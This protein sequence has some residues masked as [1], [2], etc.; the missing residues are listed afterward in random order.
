MRYFLVTYTTK[1]G[2]QIDEVVSVSKNARP[3]D[4]Q[5]CS[6]IMDYKNKKVDKCVIEGKKVDTD[7]EKLDAY[8]RQLYPSIIERLE[9]EAKM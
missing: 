7:W 6:V 9:A 2:G 1:A 3:N 8:Y 5:T 4:I